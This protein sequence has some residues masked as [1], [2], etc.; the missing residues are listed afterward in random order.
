MELPD[1]IMRRLQTILFQKA[2]SYDLP[3]DFFAA[4]AENFPARQLACLLKEADMLLFIEERALT[5]LLSYLDWYPEDDWY[6]RFGATGFYNRL[7]MLQRNLTLVRSIFWYYRARI[8]YLEAETIDGGPLIGEKELPT[9]L[10]KSYQQLGNLLKEAGKE[11]LDS[12][13]IQLWQ[14]RLARML[15]IYQ[16]PYRQSAL[17]QLERLLK[18]SETAELNYQMRLELLRC[19][20]DHHRSDFSEV[21]LLLENVTRLGDALRQNQPDPESYPIQRLQIALWESCLLQRRQQL[22][23]PQISPPQRLYLTNR[24]YLEPL[25]NVVRQSARLEPVVRALVG[26]RLAASLGEQIDTVDE[27][28]LPDLLRHWSDFEL[29]AL[30]RHYQIQQEPSLKR[31]LRI[32]EQFLGIR[33]ADNKSYPQVLY[34]AA[35]CHGRLAE[36]EG[37]D[38]SFGSSEEHLV[39]AVK[40]WH[41]LACEFPRWIS[42]ESCQVTAQDAAVQAARYC[43]NLFLKNPQAYS[44]LALEVI[45]ALVGRMEA[46][47]T[48]PAGTFAETDAA[49]GFRYHYAYV[50]YLAGQYSRAAEMFDAVGAEDDNKSAARYYGILARLQPYLEAD[51]PRNERACLYEPLINELNRFIDS[52]PRGPYAV[53]ALQL[54]IQLRQQLEQ[55]ELALQAAR[56]ALELNSTNGQ[57]TLLSL[58][59][60]SRQRAV[61]LD[62]HARGEYQQLWK[63]LSLSLPLAQSVYNELENA[64][65]NQAPSPTDR[66]ALIAGRIYGEQLCMA[67]VSAAEFG[68][69]SDLEDSTEIQKKAERLLDRWGDDK[70]VISQLWYV[71]CRALLSFA[72]KDF[73]EAQKLWYHIREAT[74][75]SDEETARYCWWESRYFGMR[76]LGQ[77][78]TAAE[79]EHAIDILLR[80]RPDE[81][82]VW[83]ERLRDLKVQ[84]Q[85]QAKS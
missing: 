31:S 5:D 68:R 32:W 41:R 71:R 10:E 38:F 28:F 69:E 73:A 19:N 63:F 65:P 26:G 61:C 21:K 30:A 2:F 78:G 50:L 8:G 13:Q 79:V 34:E 77:L 67:A 62:L 60:L 83:K 33:P 36:S 27:S 25:V 74:A 80:S 42:C 59:L 22:I 44:E 45:G 53:S 6:D 64:E 11:E 49:R 84:A 29:L 35:W 46:G 17:S 55:I 47:K 76:C 57:L 37:S 3:M 66:Q 81:E 9:A 43:Y 1:E 18:Q 85:K 72:R 16:A 51:L 82:T 4:A 48:E 40:Y 56:R 58:N 23:S 54:L 75:P 70:S 15:G 52:D 24:R 7:Q 14:V 12:A 39:A 20:F